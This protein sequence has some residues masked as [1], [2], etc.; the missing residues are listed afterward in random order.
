MIK[1]KDI[2]RILTRHIAKCKIQKT[3]SKALKPFILI[4]PKIKGQGDLG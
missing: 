4:D 2:Y 3:L 1:K